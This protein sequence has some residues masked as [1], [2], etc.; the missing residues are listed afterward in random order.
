MRSFPGQ[1]HVTVVAARMLLL[2]LLPLLLLGC[3]SKCGLLEPKLLCQQ[4]PVG[5]PQGACLCALLLQH[6]LTR[7]ALGDHL[8]LE[9]CQLLLCFLLRVLCFQQSL[10]EPAMLAVLGLQGRL[11]RLHIWPKPQL[12]LPHFVQDLLIHTSYALSLVGLELRLGQ[13]VL[14][15][16]D[17]PALLAAPSPRTD[18]TALLTSAAAGRPWGGAPSL[19]AANGPC[20]F[21]QLLDTVLAVGQ[22]GHRRLLVLHDL[23]V[24]ASQV[25]HLFFKHSCRTACRLFGNICL[26]R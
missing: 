21:T 5:C 26:C 4:C 16:A 22:L 19:E 15:L 11:Q 6:G 14:Q 20:C 9:A 18:A 13:P 12:L 7:S 17:E 25:V 23:V 10:R 8:G 3:C 2:L 24:V 1:L